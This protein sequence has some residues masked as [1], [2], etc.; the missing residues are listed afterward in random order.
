MDT[1][2]HALSGALLARATA[3][4]EATADALPLTRRIALG[5]FAAAFPDIDFIASYFSPIGYLY[6]HRG[7]THSWLM[8]PLWAALIGGL[9]AWACRDRGN[10]HRYAGVVAWSIGI[11]IVGDWITSYGT[12]MFAPLSDAR[13]DLSTTFIVDLWFTG[14]IVAALMCAWVWRRTRTPAMLGLGVLA[15]YVAF[16]FA[17]QQRAVDFAEDYA[18]GHRMHAAEIKALPRPVSP[19]NWMVIVTEADRYHYALVNLFRQHVREPVAADAG[20][21]DRLDAP[22]RPVQYAQWL[23]VNRY[24]SDTADAALAREAYS[25]PAFEFFRWFAAYPVVFRIDRGNPETCAWFEDLRFFTP[26]RLEQPF[27]YGT[28][29]DGE[30]TWK[31][32]RLVDAAHRVPVF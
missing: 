32:Y 2:T 23:V 17:L 11:H 30:G 31:A 21:F 9:W 10:W 15:A 1:L 28:C 18:R 4:R 8:L 12:I 16:Q 22:Y 25:Q 26:G 13:Y 29:R 24:G 5:F 20:F 3:P 7:I 6:Y 19:F 27:R 14:I